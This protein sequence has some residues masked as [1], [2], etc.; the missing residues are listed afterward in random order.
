M[1]NCPILEKC[2]FF[3][4]RMSA[5]PATVELYKKKYCTKDFTMC[6][7]YKVN[8]ATGKSHPTLLPNQDNL[9]A[10]AI[11]EIKS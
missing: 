7:R 5:K 11:K 4:E 2:I 6:A 3:N 10:D 9:V 1:T 8:Q